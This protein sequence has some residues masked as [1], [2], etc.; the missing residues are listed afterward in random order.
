MIATAE[1][2]GIRCVIGHGFGLGI[3]TMAEIMFACTSAN[4]IDGLECVGPLK[5]TDDIVTSKLD[6]TSGAI[7]LPRG[8]GLGV[9]L[10]EEKLAR[11]SFS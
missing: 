6:L 2:A 9:T 1:A 3:S 5:T 8:P 4:V 7:D 10:D 11:Y